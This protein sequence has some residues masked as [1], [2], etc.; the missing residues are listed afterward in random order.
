MQAH[1]Y[2]KLSAAVI[3]D[4]LHVNESYLCTRFRESAGETISSFVQHCKVKEACFLLEQGIRPARV[5]EMLDFSSP[6]Y[7][8]SVFRKIRGTT[9]AEYRNQL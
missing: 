4:A 1:L 9:P 7:F 2:E 6:S 8:T 3:A 5:S